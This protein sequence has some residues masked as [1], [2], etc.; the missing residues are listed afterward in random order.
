MIGEAKRGDLKRMVA[1]ARG[2]SK[3]R[4]LPLF[5]VAMLVYVASMIADYFV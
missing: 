3:Q 1:Y 4:A 2:S 5:H